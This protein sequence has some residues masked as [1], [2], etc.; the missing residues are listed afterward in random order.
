MVVTFVLL[1]GYLKGEVKVSPM[2]R[3]TF[4]WGVD[5]VSEQSALGG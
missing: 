1:G 3:G 4:T 5:V 2:V